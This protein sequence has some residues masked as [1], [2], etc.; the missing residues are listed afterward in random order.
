MR[1]ECHAG[2]FMNDVD[3]DRVAWKPRLRLLVVI[4]LAAAAVLAVLWFRSHAGINGMRA[5][6]AASAAMEYRPSLARLSGD[7]PFREVKPAQRG[8]EAEDTSPATA[9]VWELVTKL[10]DEGG[11]RHALGVSLLLVGRTKDAAP[12]LEQVLRSETKQRGELAV[13]IRRSHDAALLNDLAVTY[14]ALNDAAHQPLVLEAVQRAWAVERTPAIAWTRA[15]VMDSY[16]IRQRSIA[17]WRDYLALEPRSD[18]SRYARQRLAALQQP[19]EAEA[20]PAAR[21][22]L[23]AARNDAPALSS[24]VDH[25]RQEVRLWCENELLPQWGTAVLHGDP[26]AA[27]R[28]EK[29]RALGEALEKASGE[30]E[31][32][33]VARAIGNTA[34][35]ELQQ[36]ANG[37]A[38]YGAG[39][40]AA[41]HST[42]QEATADM[43][44][45]AAALHPQVTPFAWRAR[46]EHAAMLYSSNQHRQALAELQQ[47]EK[48]CGT[49]LSIAG[50]A[51]LDT[52]L[53]T[54]FI[55]VSSYKEAADHYA[56]A[57]EAYRQIGEGDYESAL[58]IRM[59]ETLD[60]MGDAAGA[61]RNLERGVEIQQRTG[62]SRHGHYAMFVG[63]F[64][65]LQADQ[66][67]QAA[68]FLD[69]MVEIDAAA[70]D[71]SQ[72][73][74]SAMWRSAYR[75]RVGL[76]EQ[77]G[78][79]LAVAQ[80]ACASIL[81]RSVRERQLAYLE[82]AK[83]FGMDGSSTEPLTGL[84][85]AFAFSIAVTI[86]SG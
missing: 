65:A 60:T 47:I 70:G 69:A 9:P 76:S 18:W 26:S 53:A 10:D 38:A 71:A 25:F 52:V 85:D 58:L 82:V 30:R 12:A 23:L 32:A 54:V 83:T 50:R 59:A 3:G 48:E 66:Q 84:D 45:A 6:V 34:G 8:T 80:R 16:H 64:H 2:T 72:T 61:L 24:D 14:L 74:T 41:K 51:R 29:I 17:A 33:D 4:P 39:S 55:Q 28:L 13:A 57:I 75:Y 77:A 62:D 27:A 81:D 5:V 35:D 37:L 22:R 15:V 11:N 49:G 19:T 79:D 40:Y 21:D 44:A 20:W 36:V 68:L 31:I 86:V 63:A 1:A 67:A 43:A 46:T 42:L 78:S 56:R 7:F 73:C